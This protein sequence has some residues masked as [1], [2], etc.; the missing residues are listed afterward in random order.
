MNKTP[1]TDKIKVMT[2][3]SNGAII[4]VK[5]P[6]SG[7]VK[8]KDAIPSFSWGS[9]D[10]RVRRHPQV[11]AQEYAKCV[12]DDERKANH[13]IATALPRLLEN[14]FIAGVKYGVEGV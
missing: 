5:G 9:M 13:L 14:A 2:A 7:W 11:V 8:C 1:L 12:V 3:A 4:E 10:Y 6:T